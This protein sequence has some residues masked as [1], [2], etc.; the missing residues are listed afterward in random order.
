MA[1]Q[2]QLADRLRIA[3]TD[4][5]GIEEKKMFGGICMMKRGNMLC[6][7]SNDDFMFRV[8]AEQVEEA[9]TRPGARHVQLGGNR[10]MSGFVWVAA[11]AIEGEKIDE[12]IK[13]VDRFNQSLP[14]K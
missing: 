1:Y 12:W 14:A 6:G 13:L 8:G 7:T 11:D 4:H 9:L 2:E 5:D 10:P 3:L